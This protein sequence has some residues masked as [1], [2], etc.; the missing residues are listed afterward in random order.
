[1]STT[2]VGRNLAKQVGDFFI[3]GSGD[4]ASAV[5]A[6]AKAQALDDILQHYYQ[7]RGMEFDGS[8][9]ALTDTMKAIVYARGKKHTKAVRKG[10]ISSAKFGLQVAA[11]AGGA[12]I[13]S[14]VPVA[15]TALGAAGGVVAG[16]SLGVGITVLDRMKRSAK[17]IYKWATDTRG[18]HRNEAAA[19][20]LHTHTSQFNRANG[21]NPADDALLVILGEEYQSVTSSNNV[22]RLADRLKSN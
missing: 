19:C 17:G 15:G 4:A 5:S 21:G 14:V 1:M 12:T 18:V 3:A 11:V 2:Y 8:K 16:L 22:A 7:R 9:I 10:V 6:E 20:L 13:G